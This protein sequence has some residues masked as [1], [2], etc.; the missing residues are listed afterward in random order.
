MPENPARPDRKSAEPKSMEPKSVEPKS[1]GLATLDRAKLDLAK[2]VPANSALPPVP[3][4][5]TS[6]FDPQVCPMLAEL[7]PSAQQTRRFQK[8]HSLVA[9]SPRAPMTF[10]DSSAAARQYRRYSAPPERF[11]LCA[12]RWP[13]RFR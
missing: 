3:A 2:L 9:K 7:R 6:R 5:A 4:L 10:L 8:T 1:S 13:A 11:P 12:A